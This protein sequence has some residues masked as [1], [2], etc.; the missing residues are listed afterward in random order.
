MTLETQVDWRDWAIRWERQQEVHLP[1]REERFRLMLEVIEHQ[2]GPGALHVLDLCSGPASIGR[3]ILDRFP[4]AT[5]VAADLD[6]FSLE[7]GRQT[8]GRDYP[9][10]I[11]WLEADLR[12]DAWLE[13]LEP[14]SFDA[15]VSAT[16]IHWFK[17]EEQALLYQRLASLAKVGAVFANADHLPVGSPTIAAT[18]A[19]L[20][21]ATTQENMARPDAESWTDYWEA[22]RAEPGFSDL[23]E[24]RERRFGPDVNTPDWS[25]DYHRE[26]LL[27]AGFREVAEVWRHHSDAILVAIR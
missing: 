24:E 2:L 1:S 15:I 21:E 4:A 16:A 9:K 5:V 3:R 7:I 12:G 17:P 26:A 10:R 6:P 11:S 23:L 19:Q 18:S 20:M 22:A 8:V 13:Q 27:G 14:G 25:V